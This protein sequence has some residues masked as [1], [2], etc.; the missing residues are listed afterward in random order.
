LA[1]SGISPEPVKHRTAAYILLAK[2][3]KPKR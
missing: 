1:K 2:N 3:P